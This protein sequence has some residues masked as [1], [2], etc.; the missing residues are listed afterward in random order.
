MKREIKIHWRKKERLVIMLMIWFVLLTY[1]LT[2]IGD[3]TE[4]G[5]IETKHILATWLMAFVSFL[6]GSISGSK[7]SIKIRNSIAN[8]KGE[9]NGN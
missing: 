1:L 5:Q 3:P 6:A 2:K 9:E 7:I 8:K 4:C